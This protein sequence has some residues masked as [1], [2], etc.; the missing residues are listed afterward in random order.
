MSPTVRIAPPLTTDL[1]GL[2]HSGC[3]GTTMAS[4][5]PRDVVFSQGD[6]ADSVK[7]LEDGMVKLSVSSRSG[8]EAVVAMLRPGAFFAESVLVGDAVRRESATAVTGASVLSIPKVE[9]VRLLRE[10]H[11]FSDRFIAHALARSIRLEEDVVDQLLNSCEKRLARALL[12]LGHRDNAA[13]AGRVL[14]RCSQ[15]T[16]A[17]MVGTTRSRVNF[18]MNKFKKLGYIDCRGGMK[19]NDSLM[20]VLLRD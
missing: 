20:A 4:Y 1:D 15:Q 12:L 17:E 3:T 13:R 18:F 16:L 2:L 14:P 19:V 9:M 7:Y 11:E 6:A 10:K 5:Q 8:Q